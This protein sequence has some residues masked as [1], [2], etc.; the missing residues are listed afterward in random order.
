MIWRDDSAR[1]SPAG[2]PSFAQ[3]NGHS[4]TRGS[5]SGSH[6]RN[7]SQQVTRPQATRSARAPAAARGRHATTAAGSPARSR[8]RNLRA[9]SQAAGRLAACQLRISSEIV[10]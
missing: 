5:R 3:K 9:R 6:A 10:R 7:A 8:R 4:L 2:L 1:A